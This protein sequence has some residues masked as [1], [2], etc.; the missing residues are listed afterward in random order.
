MGPSGR[1]RINLYNKCIRQKK[2]FDDVSVSPVVRQVL[3]H[4]GYTPNSKDFLKAKKE[5]KG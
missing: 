1:W 4:W 3:Q 5:F 2:N